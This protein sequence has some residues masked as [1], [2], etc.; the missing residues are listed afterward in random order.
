MIDTLSRAI[1]KSDQQDVAEM[2]FVIGSLQRMAMNGD[3][4]VLTVD[5]HRKS[6]GFDSNPIDDILGSTAK[7]AVLDAAL[8]L[9]REQGKHE[10]ILKIT[11]RDIEEQELALQFDGLTGCWQSLG[12][13]GD[14]REDTQKAQVIQAIRNLQDAGDVPTTTKIAN[15]AGIDKAYVSRML[16]ELVA[17]GLV[18][19]GEKSGREVPYHV[20]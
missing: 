17:S 3:M 4:A 2:T 1:G 15:Q 5:H 9:Y 16:A 13:A 18:I 12:A 8:G 7:A 10:A 11:G 14:V 19:R 6:N 20:L